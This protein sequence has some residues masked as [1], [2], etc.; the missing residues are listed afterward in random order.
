MQRT[1]AI[2]SS[3]SLKVCRSGHRHKKLP[4]FSTASNKAFESWHRLANFSG[5]EPQEGQR[6]NV[7]FF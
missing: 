4:R 3:S 1:F 2:G 6:T 5:E 7:L